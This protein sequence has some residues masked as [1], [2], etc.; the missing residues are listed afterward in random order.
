MPALQDIGICLAFKFNFAESNQKYC[1]MLCSLGIPMLFVDA[2]VES[3]SKQ[4]EADVL[5]MDNSAGFFNLISNMKERGITK[6]GFVGQANHCRSFFE[7]YMA[8]RNAMFINDLEIDPAFCLTEVHPH[9]P[10]YREYLYMALSKLKKMPELFICA[11]D[12]VAIDVLEGFKKLGIRCPEDVKL[13][14][15]DDSPESK[16]MTPS[17]S[18]CHIH[19]QAM[20][21][22]AANILLSRIK[23]PDL[24]YRITYTETDIILRESTK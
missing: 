8:F 14:G 1:E 13:F 9:D 10:S 16:V 18:T 5:M 2:P 22:S 6:I 21:Y 11:N 4:L 20:G 3:Y 12:F 7:R 19:S 23:Q 24:N 17:L 15:F